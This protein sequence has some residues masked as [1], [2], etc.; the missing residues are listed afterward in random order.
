LEDVSLIL[1]GIGLFILSISLLTEG[2]KGFAGNNLRIL[3]TRYI[4]GKYSAILAGT[5][6]AML[7]QSSSATIMA[8]IGFV[9]AGLL[10]FAQSV[11][12][13]MGANLGTTSTTWIVSVLGFKFSIG[14]FAMPV[15][16]LGSLLKV[17][18][19]ERQQHLGVAL[20]G[21]GLIFIAL[22]MLQ[23]GMAQYSGI[24][25]GL[26]EE[27]FGYSIFLLL[28]LGILITVVLQSS[29]AA[30][31]TT[32]TAL[33]QGVISY[34]QALVLAIGQNLGTTVKAFI[35]AVGASRAAQRTALCHILFNIITA[36]IALLLLS[37]LG[38]I[39]WQLSITFFDRAEPLIALS[40]FH[41]IF[42]LLG[43]L[44]FLPLIGKFSAFI[45]YLRPDIETG[46][47][48]NLDDSVLEVPAVALEVAERA[49]KVVAVSMGEL[50]SKRGERY[51]FSKQ[52][53]A[54]V[55]KTLDG[56]QIFLGKV[57]KSAQSERE[58][59]Q[60]LSLLHALEHSVRL[61]ELLG[62]LKELELKTASV[63]YKIR[64][65]FLDH[66]QKVIASD[67]S[68][69]DGLVI[70]ERLVNEIKSARQLMRAEALEQAAKKEKGVHEAFHIAEES[71]FWDSAANHLWRIA[72]HL[73]GEEAE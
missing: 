10:T 25:E 15:I 1:G 51:R 17:L 30:L 44:L 19:N 47:L 42:N 40:L 33:H 29:S 26:L 46:P 8:T 11:G 70:L 58:S 52:E 66:F 4:S 64:E 61:Y 53:L 54:E 7:V 9:S 43:V 6:V 28:A 5:L 57:G 41:T 50:V 31:A 14:L 23:G 71:R 16:F 36:L 21:F 12:V 60:F 63:P 67:E 65:N 59:K 48:K 38:R 39:C 27:Q 18:G 22:E 62:K 45:E 3:L 35:A 34:D 2:L 13:V 37:W 49:M 73:C 68:D 56:I 24:I 72:F 20:A 32:L 55:E 69:V